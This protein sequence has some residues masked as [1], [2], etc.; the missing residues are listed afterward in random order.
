MLVL[1]CLFGGLFGGLMALALALAIIAT[2]L[3]G[4]AGNLGLLVAIGSACSTMGRG[5]ADKG[6]KGH[7]RNNVLHLWFSFLVMV[8]WFWLSRRNGY[9]GRMIVARSKM[10]FPLPLS[11]PP[12]HVR[13]YR[14]DL[15]RVKVDSSVQQELFGLLLIAAALAG[16]TL[17]F[18]ATFAFHLGFSVRFLCFAVS[19]VGDSG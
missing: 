17:A 6:H 11:P 2:I 3:A 19:A 10:M 16:I 18:V 1:A 7:Q 8:G 15:D 13:V 9:S 14:F 12:L 5:C 4:L